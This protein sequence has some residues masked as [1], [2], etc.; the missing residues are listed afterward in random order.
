MGPKLTSDE[1]L[2]LLAE[3]PSCIW[4]LTAEG[5]RI[6]AE[7][8]NKGVLTSCTNLRRSIGT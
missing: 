5:M 3:C 8:M 4:R 6:E 1:V 7:A 2:G